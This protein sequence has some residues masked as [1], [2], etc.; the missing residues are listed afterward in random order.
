MKNL[1]RPVLA[2]IAL[3]FLAACADPAD[4]IAIRPG[5]TSDANLDALRPPSGVTYRYKMESGDI[6]VPVSLS[7]RSKRR[8]ARVYDYTGTMAIRFP[9]EVNFAEIGALVAQSFGV[10][11]IK[12]SGSTASFP[13]A[14]RTD[15][16]FRS[17]S[18]DFLRSSGRYVPHDCFAVLG[19]C[20]YRAFEGDQSVTLVSETTES[21]GIWTT[22]TRPAAGSQGTGRQRMIYSLDRNGV[23]V[24]LVVSSTG[25]GGREPLVFRRQ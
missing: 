7:L 25:Q 23:M 12:F 3:S 5:L 20:T 11:D 2:L 21:G 16:R 4:S 15:N 22:V 18:S 24:D 6:P 1:Y 19:R 8:S 10:S 9:D 14:L 17:L 13:V